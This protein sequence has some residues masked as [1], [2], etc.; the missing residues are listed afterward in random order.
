MRIRR[1]LLLAGLA[2]G[3]FVAPA[4]AAE[5]I[6]LGKVQLSGCQTVKLFERCEITAELSGKINNPF[7]PNE[8]R[9]EA[10]FNPPRGQPTV[11]HG[12]Y[13]EGLDT[14]EEDGKETVKPSGQGVWKIRF[15]PRATGRWL[16]RLRLITAS[17]AQSGPEAPFLVVESAS[18]GFVRLDKKRGIF[19]F[20][21][22]A[23]FLPIG[24][25]L[26]WGPGTQPLQA[27]DKWM[28]ELS[29]QKAN[30]I[31]V[32]MAPW[33]F[34][35]EN[36]EKGLGRYDQLRAWQ[37][38]EL[39]ER[40]QRMGIY[41]QLCLLNHGAFSRNQDPDW[42][43][44][45]Y[46]QKLGGMC[47]IPDEFATNPKAKMMYQRLL[48]YMV[49][50]WGYSPNLAAWELFNEGDF[51]EFR[52]DDLNAWTVE[53]SQYLRSIDPIQRPITTS[54]HHEVP[55]VVW[56]APAID[57]VQV[58]V[59]DSRDFPS[60]FAGGLIKDLKDK[61]HKPVFIGEF[62]WIGD[63][64]RKFD[65][66]GIHMHEGLWGSLV[67]GA[68]ASAMI[69]YWDS[70][71][72]PNKL[73]KQYRALEA[74]WR[75]EATDG[76]SLPV[77]LSFSDSDLAG[78]GIRRGG[79]IY[80]WVKNKNHSVDQYLAYR[81]EL[82]KQKLTAARGGTVKP[83]VYPVRVV[84]GATVQFKGLGRFERYRVEWWDTYRGR[85]ISR[86]FSRTSKGEVV[87]DVPKVQYDLAM[88]LIAL[89]WYE[90]GQKP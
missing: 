59:Y 39:F 90:Q 33:G 34:R 35:L 31:R 17:G 65:D 77:N 1:L 8:V 16:C 74:F 64:V 84:N 62:G 85:I 20:D 42:H 60:L 44:N 87:V 48:Q 2:S 22:G 40:C 55:D 68:S 69:W 61:Y 43:N 24:Q 19:Q 36:K 58:H 67:G 14:V 79:R 51:G 15:S 12:F 38:D 30:Y 88:K 66:I 46:N 47:R 21:R 13:Y 3:F 26:C 53:M 4:W 80:G 45:P 54:F 89:Q 25:N 23:I 78:W 81:C 50:R 28:S 57:T 7:D 71:V 82:A 37:L 10:T 72:S 76:K 63:F 29:K 56:N 11:V 52:V 73:E 75:D 70:Y 83:I 27:Y 18:Q 32:W 49:N 9:L 41:V 6:R 86:G 5:P